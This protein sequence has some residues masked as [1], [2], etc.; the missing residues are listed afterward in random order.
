M[1]DKVIITAALSGAGTYK[2]NNPNVPYTAQEFAEES[3][4]CLK[5]GAAMVHVHSRLDD[6]TPT[7]EVDKI[8]AIRPRVVNLVGHSRGAIVSVRIAAQLA[9]KMPD[10]QWSGGVRR[11]VFDVHLH[12]RAGWCRR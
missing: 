3:A 11:D 9:K 8:R 6:G 1:A 7:H 10:V 12:A 5:A 2:N 4:K